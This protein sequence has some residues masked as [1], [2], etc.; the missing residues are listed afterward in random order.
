[1]AAVDPGQPPTMRWS[2][3]TPDGRLELDGSLAIPLERLGLDLSTRYVSRSTGWH[4]PLS[5]SVLAGD[6]RPAVLHLEMISSPSD[7]ETPLMLQAFLNG[8]LQEV[9]TL[10]NDGLPNQ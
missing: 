6:L 5:P 10:P 4:L 1:M 7:T 9:A 3:G 8:T 2:P